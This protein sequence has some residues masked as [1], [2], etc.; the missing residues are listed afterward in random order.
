VFIIHLH[1]SG[2]VIVGP[3]L[4]LTIFLFI[5]KHHKGKLK[6]SK[7]ERITSIVAIVFVIIAFLPVIYE[8]KFSDEGN[9]MRIYDF[10]Q[11]HPGI[12][13]SIADTT[14]YTMPFFN[15]PI[16]HVINTAPVKSVNYFVI[17]L[18]LLI[19]LYV[20]KMNNVDL[21]RLLFFIYVSIIVALF[22]SANIVGSM[23]E[24]L[25]WWFYSVVGLLYFFN[26]IV[27]FKI[28][29]KVNIQKSLI[30]LCLLIAVVLIFAQVGQ[31]NTADY[32]RYNEKYAQIYGFINPPP[33][34]TTYLYWQAGSVNHGQWGTAAG[35]AYKLIKNGH[36]VCVDDHWRTMFGK[37]LLCKGKT[38]IETFYLFDS[39]YF[40]AT[41]YPDAEYLDYKG[42]V[43]LRKPEDSDE[44]PKI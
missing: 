20:F 31:P 16:E 10:F 40:N 35:I 32:Q 36:S 39:K 11:K 3:L 38:N 2:I 19:P 17:I 24:Y 29:E 41:D 25:L 28:L 34:T 26:L 42:T 9:I 27:I 22:C 37:D 18:V 44:P 6:L 13:H 5:K 23:N 7:K 1:V 30:L 33:N 4:L 14:N 15:K 12:Q 21:K 43:I 8:Q